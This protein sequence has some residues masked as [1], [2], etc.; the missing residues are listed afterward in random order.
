[1]STETA[2]LTPTVI[3]REVTEAS[4][5]ELRTAGELT[6]VLPV[7]LAT[8][9]VVAHRH[10]ATVLA[11]LTALGLLLPRLALRDIPGFARLEEALIPSRSISSGGIKRTSALASVWLK[12]GRSV[13]GLTSSQFCAWL[14]ASS[15]VP[16][17]LR[18]FP[19][20]LPGSRARAEFC[21]FARIGRVCAG[22]SLAR[23][24]QTRDSCW[25][26]MVCPVLPWLG[27]NTAGARLCTWPPTNT[28][29][30]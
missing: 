29:F 23:V 28:R 8:A 27:V 25:S 17:P 22:S 7:A 15:S 2:T 5:L 21:A 26:L 20:S 4:K 19:S 9:V 30:R 18:E 6:L 10:G 3:A 16:G 12:G 13:L 14:S 11:V 1:M 24:A